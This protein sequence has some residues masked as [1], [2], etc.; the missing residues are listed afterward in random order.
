MEKEHN[1]ND[2]A[3]SCE[4]AL[5]ALSAR[6]DQGAFSPEEWENFCLQHPSCKKE[7][8]QHYAL[9][10]SMEG[11]EIPEPS[12]QMDQR[13]YA[14]LDA[15]EQEAPLQTSSRSWGQSLRALLGMNP[16]MSLALGMILFLVGIVTGTLLK[17]SQNLGEIQQLSQ[18]IQQMREL[19][20]LTLIKQTSPTDR[21]K[22]I[23]LTRSISKPD[24]HIIS[25]L[26]ETLNKDPN[27]NV[28]LSALEALAPYA[29]QPQVRKLLIEAIPHQDAPLV[30][31]ALAELMLKL[32][33]VQSVN[34]WKRLLDSL[35]VEPEVKT[36]V[37]TTIN[38]LS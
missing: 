13:F 5:K 16:G 24:Q 2:M 7:L 4:E 21:L 33:E 29:N 32:Q 23:H 22:G 11:M 20:M 31:M 37:E 26:A 19:T 18:E 10:V 8:E 17:P 30:Q 36:Q 6:L 9:W 35:E 3:K 14:M 12:S 25:A 34:A 28:R 38:Q 15:Y 27:A 1:T